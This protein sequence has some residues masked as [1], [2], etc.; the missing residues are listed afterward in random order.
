MKSLGVEKDMKNGIV[1]KTVN[2]YCHDRYIYFLSDVPHLIK[3]TR[4]CWFSS[5]IGGTQCMW[6]CV[7]FKS[8]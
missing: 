2:R 6:V 5:A 3:T 8:S 4:N 1:Y 7:T